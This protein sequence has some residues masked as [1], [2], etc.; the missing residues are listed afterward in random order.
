[1]PLVT[2]SG[3][4]TGW[5]PA[6]GGSLNYRVIS[7]FGVEPGTMPEGWYFGR[8]SAVAA[9]DD[10]RVYVT[11]RGRHA[12]AIVVFDPDGEYVGDFGGWDRGPFDVPHG[13]RLDPS[14]NV[15]LIDCG[16]H[17]LHQFTPDG[18]LLRSIGE[19]GVSGED[20]RTFG[21]PTDCAFAPDGA[22]FVSDGY[23][24]SRVVKLDPE[25]R[26]V[27]AWGRRGTGPG[28]FNTPH[29]VAVDASGMVFVSDRNNDR[30][31]VFDGEG[32]LQHITTQFGAVMCISILPDGETWLLAHRRIAEILAYDALGG[33]AL[34]VDLAGEKILGS[35]PTPGHWIHRGTNGF[36]FVASLAGNVVR[37]TPGPVSTSPYFGGP[38]DE[39]RILREAGI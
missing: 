32:R 7:R 11:Q 6:E 23:G 35:F 13:L 15:W 36:V 9:A 31:Q 38:E 17:Q 30:I 14:G 33:K 26:F 25:G 20:E 8:V 1:V 29:S 21:S 37:A 39:R 22:I 16:N 27:R 10:G 2:N 19:R 24:N 4:S 5:S 18:E 12:P 34:K 3:L 28:E